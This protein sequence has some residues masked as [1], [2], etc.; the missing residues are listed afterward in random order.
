MISSLLNPFEKYTEKLLSIVGVIFWLMGSYIAS[1]CNANFD[2][3]LDLHFSNYQLSFQK[4]LLENG[5][6]LLVLFGLLFLVGKLINDKTRAIDLIATVLIARIPFYFLPLFNATNK[7]MLD[8][9]LNMQD[10]MKFAQE[11]MIFLLVFA[12]VLL[13]AVVWSITLLYNGYKI[14]VHAKASKSTV[15]FILALVLAEILSK[16]FIYLLIL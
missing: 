13:L 15:L 7:L 10:M 11:N 9:N 4:V 2:G 8:Q 5:I 14:S 1:N 6:N 3:V 12:L 16:F